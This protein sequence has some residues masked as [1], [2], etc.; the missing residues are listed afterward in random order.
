MNAAACCTNMHR[1]HSGW[2]QRSPSGSPPL[3]LVVSS[4]HHSEEIAFREQLDF[5]PH[6]YR[7]N[8]RKPTFNRTRGDAGAGSTREAGALLSYLLDR[9][10]PGG[11]SSLPAASAFLHIDTALHNVVWPRWLACLRPNLSEP[12]V[13]LSPAI[14]PNYNPSLLSR[15]SLLLGKLRGPAAARSPRYREEEKAEPHPLYRKVG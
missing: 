8:K 10:E 12:L 14:V 1:P 11:G 2:A 13:S 4:L 9:L 3:E 15:A 5:M 7:H 6:F